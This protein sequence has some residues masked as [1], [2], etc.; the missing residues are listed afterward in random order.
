MKD[1]KLH[2]IFGNFLAIFWVALFYFIKISVSP[3]ELFALILATW[4]A[5]LFPDVDLKK[6]K[7][8][9]VVALVTA[10]VV[11][12]F[13]VFYFQPTWYYGPAYFLILYFLLRYI[14]SKHRGVMHSFKFSI[15]FSILL[16]FLISL[17]LKFSRSEYL[18][19]FAIILF[20]YNLHL[21]L[22]RI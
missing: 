17:F 19:W 12:F 5:S 1:W 14:P 16:V 21:M 2:F 15:I 3:L 4:F 22:D 11:A 10:G 6:S 8:R 7:I 9:D 13:Y 20:S 18:F